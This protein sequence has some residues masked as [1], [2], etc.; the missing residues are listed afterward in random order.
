LAATNSTF[1]ANQAGSGGGPGSAGF[2]FN[3]SGQRST[4]GSGGG[5][6]GGIFG[7]GALVLY[8]CTVSRNLGGNGS[9]AD[10]TGN[11]LVTANITSATPISGNLLDANPHP[12]IITYSRWG[13]P[14]GAGGSG[15][16]YSQNSLDMVLC[17]VSGNV[18]GAGGGGGASYGGYMQ[19]FTGGGGGSGGI[20]AVFCSPGNGLALV[21][22]TMT[23]NRGGSGGTGGRGDADYAGHTGQGPDGGGGVGGIFNTNTALAANVINTIVASNFGGLGGAGAPWRGS[24]GNAGA[25]DL[26]G[27]FSSLGHNLIGLAD[28]SSGFTNGVNGDLAGSGGAPI[29]PL[30]GPLTGNG[31]PTPTM[32]LLHGSAALDAGDD[33]LLRPPYALTTDQRG[34]PRKSGS[35][36]D[37]GA[38]EFQFLSAHKA[39]HAPT[40][41]G[42]PSANGNLQLNTASK[43]SDSGAPVTAPNFQLTFSDNTPGATFTILA[44]TNLALPVN[45]WSV[46]GQPVQIGPHLF[47]FTDLQAANYPQRFYRVSSP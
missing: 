13:G 33:A 41:S 30:L 14:G 31:G 16:I 7:V 23:A 35:H 21:A 47:H 46:L 29:D 4:S 44:T 12:E 25:P 43:G 19:F 1:N 15:G 6:G 24:S 8:A 32:A 28:G 11:A 45:N 9:S 20:G 18:G 27:S 22:C 40:L 37:I 5:Q 36:V 2:N 26:Q 42:A 17:T 10:F 39:T 38:F 3:I 34:F